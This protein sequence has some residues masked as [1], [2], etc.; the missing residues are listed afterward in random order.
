M[1]LQ[2]IRLFRLAATA[3]ALV[4]TTASSGWAQSEERG[5]FELF[6]ALVR[7]TDSDS[8]LETEAY[9]LRGG[10]RFNDTWGLEGSVSRLNEDE[11]DVW[12][13]DVSLKAHALRSERFDLYAVAGPGLIQVESEDPEAT[14]HLGVGL[15]IGLGER[16]YLRPEVRGRWLTDELHFDEGVVDYSV[17]FGWRF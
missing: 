14:V 12:F 9:G 11:V 3:A 17:G 1:K 6:G 16:S 4:I 2:Q 7:P 13:G 10:Y 15:E 8:D 5:S